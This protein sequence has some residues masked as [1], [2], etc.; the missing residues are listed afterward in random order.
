[1]ERAERAAGHEQNLRVFFRHQP[2]GGGWAALAVAT[3][4]YAGGEIAIIPISGGTI[5]TGS[6]HKF[7]AVFDLGLQAAATNY[8]A[9]M[10]RPNPTYG[11]NLGNTLE[12]NGSPPSVALFYS[13]VQ[14]GFNAVRIPCA[15]D[16]NATTNITST[17]PTTR[18][19]PLTWRR[20]NRRLTGPSLR[21]CM[22]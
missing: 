5:T 12:L 17:P 13:A 11:M 18:S 15:W 7:D 21:E 4:A 1:M 22:S 20:S 2:G 6:S 3:N 9:S 14:H 19:I 10:P 8:P 16:L